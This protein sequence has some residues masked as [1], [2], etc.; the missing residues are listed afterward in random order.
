MAKYNFNNSKYSWAHGK[1]PSGRGWWM[2]ETSNGTLIDIPGSKTLTE[3]KK[4]VTIKAAEMGIP[5]GS[6]LYVAP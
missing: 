1:N 5:S 4:A 6:T 3:A 2:F